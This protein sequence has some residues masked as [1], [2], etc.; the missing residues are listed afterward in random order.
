MMFSGLRPMSGMTA[1]MMMSAGTAMTVS[2]T[3]PTIA[4]V[5]PRR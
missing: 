4:S 5:R 3:R 1:R 2:V